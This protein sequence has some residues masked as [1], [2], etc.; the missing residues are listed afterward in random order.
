MVM[1]LAPS[2]VGTDVM[3]IVK[4]SK[5]NVQQMLYA[6]FVCCRQCLYVLCMVYCLL[7]NVYYTK[8]SLDPHHTTAL[9]TSPHQTTQHLSNLHL[10]TPH[11]T[12]PHQYNLHHTSPHHTAAYIPRLTTP[13]YT[14]PPT[15]LHSLD[16]QSLPELFHL[17]RRQFTSV[18]WEYIK[19]PQEEFEQLSR[20]YRLWVSQC[21]HACTAFSTSCLLRWCCVLP[22]CDTNT[23]QTGDLM[24]P[25][26]F[27][28]MAYTLKSNTILYYT[29]LYYTILYYTI[30]YYT[31]LYYTILYYTILYYTILYYTILYY[32]ILYYTILYYTIL[33]YTILY[34]NR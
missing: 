20:F 15:P 32:T 22:L 18:E 13:L 27:L 9:Y 10:T 34:Y 3:D 28:Y 30:L 11:Y 17:M 19:Y 31:I 6:T 23:S 4:P 26:H 25:R 21:R 33:Y 16:S 12:T 14:S 2:A 29:I 5:E 8:C 1:Y 24:H 7:N